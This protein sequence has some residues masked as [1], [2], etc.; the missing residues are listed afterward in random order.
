[1]AVVVVATKCKLVKSKTHT[2][3]MNK[4]N[5]KEDNKRKQ[6]YILLLQFFIFLLDFH[7]PNKLVMTKLHG[8]DDDHHQHNRNHHHLNDSPQLYFIYGWVTL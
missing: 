7:S 4:Q 6:V 2:H 8:N 3:K 5:R 1:M